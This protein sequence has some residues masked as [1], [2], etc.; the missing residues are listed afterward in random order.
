MPQT[1]FVDR[2]QRSRRSMVALLRGGSFVNC[3]P[4]YILCSSPR[5]C[6]RRLLGALSLRVSNCFN[7]GYSYRTSSSQNR[8]SC[9][10]DM[11]VD[12]QNLSCDFG[13]QDHPNPILHL[14]K[15]GSLSSRGTLPLFVSIRAFQ[16]DL[17]SWTE[18]CSFINFVAVPS[19]IGPLSKAFAYSLM[20]LSRC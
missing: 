9:C 4:F 18:K 14:D 11:S 5:C 17:G 3:H 15:A 16:L 8:G 6:G 10:Q 1:P 2:L 20:F 19:G 7:R 12:E 13:I